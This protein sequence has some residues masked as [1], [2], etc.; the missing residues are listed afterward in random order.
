MYF[1]SDP[2]TK[3]WFLLFGSPVPVW[4]ITVLYIVTVTYIGPKFM[5]NRK[6]YSLQTFM[7]VYNIG[8]VFASLYMF[9]EVSL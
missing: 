7:I 4:I 8:L 3:D 9:I 5:E 2:R 6:P 1:I